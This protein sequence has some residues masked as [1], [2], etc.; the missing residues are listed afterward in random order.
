MPPSPRPISNDLFA[1]LADPTRR[2]L[3]DRLAAHGPVT[4]S[5]LAHD[6]EVTR[7]AIVKHLGVLLEAGVVTSQRHGNEV[8]YALVPGALAPATDWLERVGNRWDRRL[9]AL[10]KRVDNA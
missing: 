7:Q 4:A 3:I 6:Y 1:S 9:A 5:V 10:R 8:R 2:D